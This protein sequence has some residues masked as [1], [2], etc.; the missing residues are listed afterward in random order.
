MS[1]AKTLT[2]NNETYESIASAAREFG[3]SRKL[4][5]NRL[6]KGWTPEQAVGL[7]PKPNNLGRGKSRAVE[8]DGVRFKSI[9]D[10]A[11]HYG[12]AY[13]H[14][15]EQIK[16]GKTFKEALGLEKNDNILTTRSP[17]LSKQWHPTKNK[18]L[19][20]EDV[21]PGSGKKVWWLCKEGHEWQAVI[22][23]RNRGMG[24]PYC[25][26]QRVTED[27]N[28]EKSYPE[29]VM[30]WNWDKNKREPNRFSPRSKENVW[31]VCSK[32]HTWQATIQNRTRKESSGS[33]PYCNNRKL[34]DDNSLQVKRP[35]L[36]KDWHP[37]K[38]GELTP[39]DVTAGGGQKVWWTC[40]HAHSWR[41][42][43]GARVNSGTGCPKCSLQT[44]R[45]EIAVYTEVS[46]IFDKVSWQKKIDGYECDIYL[47]DYKIGIEVDGVYWHKMRP[48][49]E[50]RKSEQFDKRGIQLFRM[51]EMGLEHLSERDISFKWSNDFLPIIIELL[52][53]VLNYAELD[54]KDIGSINDYIS[55]NRLRNEKLYRKIVSELPAPPPGE[56]LGDHSEKLCNEWAYDLN[57]P[58]TPKHFRPASNKNVWWRCEVGHTWKTSINNRYRQNTGCPKCPKEKTIVVTK[59]WNFSSLY[60]EASKEWHPTKNG[61]LTPGEIRPKSGLK[62]W[63][64]CVK[65][66]EWKALAS[67]R[68]NGSGCPYCYG[69][70]ASDENNLAEA[71][72]E[73]LESWDYNKNVD[74]NPSELTPYVNKKV[75]WKCK[76][77]L[78]LLFS[79][80]NIKTKR[81]Y[82]TL[83]TCAVEPKL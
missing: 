44:S 14:V 25:A 52:K 70:F 60:P 73:L 74:L 68:A 50:I 41:A 48:K 16:K 2:I 9:K 10:A 59:D 58:L 33:C 67:S 56:S 31:W 75:W 12:R 6:Q 24:C 43:V 51:R 63:W 23:S 47:D 4:L 18:E 53:Q 66:H 19:S 3:I 15:I 27:N 62:A 13:T 54:Q 36:A 26:G 39:S 32:N 49:A 28:F 55:D 71:Y 65:G 76:E 79:P 82:R 45:V 11:A 46:A 29:L 38:N 5:S 69:R 30:E 35:D 34:C 21:S 7:E 80:K 83:A 78:L 61:E 77:Y 42:S 22:N 17:E 8:I 64:I 40:K 57:I 20:P 1:H 81:N 37:T 72:P